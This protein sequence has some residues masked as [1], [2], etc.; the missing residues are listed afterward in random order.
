MFKLVSQQIGMSENVFLR[1]FRRVDRDLIPKVN[2]WGK[3]SG[4]RVVPLL[5]DVFNDNLEGLIEI[6]RFSWWGVGCFP[7][8]VIGKYPEVSCSQLLLRYGPG[9]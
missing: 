5:L 1:L 8:S 7:A 9:T 2:G 4:L 6:R 3:E